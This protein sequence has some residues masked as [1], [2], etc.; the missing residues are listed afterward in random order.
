MILL[1]FEQLVEPSFSRGL[2]ELP[3]PFGSAS[4]DYLLLGLQLSMFL[5]YQTNLLSHLWLQYLYFFLFNPAC[6]LLESLN[7]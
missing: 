4:A 1:E 3:F 7:S 6:W 2:G 5:G